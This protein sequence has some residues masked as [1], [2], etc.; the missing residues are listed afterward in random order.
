MAAKPIAPLVSGLQKHLHQAQQRQNQQRVKQYQ[1]QDTVGQCV[2]ALPIVHPKPFV[3]S[4][5]FYPQQHS[6]MNSSEQP[7]AAPTMSHSALAFGSQSRRDVPQTYAEPSW[8]AQGSLDLPDSKRRQP[9][10]EISGETSLSAQGADTSVDEWDASYYTQLAQM[11]AQDRQ[12]EA[13]DSFLLSQAAA[14][15]TAAASAQPSYDCSMPQAAT[16]IEATS[17]LPWTSPKTLDSRSQAD[18]YNN[19][20]YTSSRLASLDDKPLEDTFPG[21]VEPVSATESSTPIARLA[22]KRTRSS[23]GLGGLVLHDPTLP[24]AT[25]L[26]TTPDRSTHNI[27]T[28]SATAESARLGQL[29]GT[30]RR[31]DESPIRL[32]ERIT[33]T[34]DYRTQCVNG[35]N[36]D[37][38]PDTPDGR[39]SV[40]DDLIEMWKLLPV[41]KATV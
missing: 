2:M 24:S 37:P 25:K 35:V 11:Q 36:H 39:R 40:V 7:S 21:A 6:Y 14:A 33:T 23:S 16:P 41:K 32:K 18:G 1:R 22:R 29:R 13:L 26:A 30:K 20:D 38:D 9:K 10:P 28:R 12:K 19:L 17:P 8:I 15:T 5:G 27:E 4:A 34:F 3:Q 31:K